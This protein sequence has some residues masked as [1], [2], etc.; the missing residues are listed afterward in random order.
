MLNNNLFH[1][2][3]IFAFIILVLVF[4][5]WLLRRFLP[6]KFKPYNATNQL[7]IVSNHSLG[8]K[9]K[10]TLIE[11]DDQYMLLGVTE[12]QITLLHKSSVIPKIRQF[13]PNNNN[14]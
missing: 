4:V 2:T 10:L 14:E 8:R 5:L 3:A 13:K 9:E 7:K 1:M 6:E 12:N 11:I